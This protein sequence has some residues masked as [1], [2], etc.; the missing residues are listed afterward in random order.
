V[1]IDKWL[2]T[3]HPVWLK[4]VTGTDYNHH[5]SK[6]QGVSPLLVRCHVN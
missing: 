5:T 2:N 1:A 4:E 3:T 6:L